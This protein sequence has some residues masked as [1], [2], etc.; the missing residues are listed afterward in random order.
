MND[1]TS[2]YVTD[3]GYPHGYYPELN[4]L[5][6]RLALARVALRSPPFVTACELGFGQGVSIN[7]HA[8]AAMTRW[9]GN[10]F[11]PAQVAFAEEAA[12]AAGSGIALS[13]EAFAEFCTRPDL[14]DC[15]FVG[16][17]GVWSW[18]SE[19]NRAVIVDFLRRK[20]K[21]G[22]VVYVGYNALP[23]WAPPAAL[24]HLLVTHTGRMTAPGPGLPA[25]IDAAFDFAA[26]LLETDP[27]YARLYPSVAS[28]LATAQKHHRHYLAHEYLNRDW[29]PMYFS[30]LAESLAAAKLT[31]A[32]SAHFLDHIDGLNLTPRQQAFL[33]DIPDLQLRE[34]ARDF[35]T[36]VQFRR[37]YWVKGARP[38][39][40]LEQLESLRGIRIVLAKPRS[41]V[42][43]T[44]IGSCG[45]ASLD[46]QIY[47]PILAALDDHKVRTIAEIEAG[48]AASGIVPAQLFQAVTVLVGTGDLAVAQDP[49]ATMQAKPRTDRLNAWLMRKARSDWDVE[50]LASPVTGGGVPLDRIEQLFLLARAEG[51][52]RTEWSTLVHTLLSSHGQS[53][54]RDGRTLAGEEM[55]MALDRE[56][57][58]F[59]ERRLPILAAL[60]VA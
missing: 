56:C 55:R 16:L 41:E 58:E 45:E 40:L 14:P 15:D 21:V 59:C 7:I 5:R 3:V 22:G 39:H 33:A 24:R 57:Q 27:A 9:Y 42:T 26:K 53:L 25:R 10:D 34:T 52:P 23:G 6:A 51:R 8:A 44:A 46:A 49:S 31:Y 43:L 17:Q 47:G 50:V 1:W 37:T 60:M 48:L 29:T 32:C 18:I 20:L 13:D 19:T 2:G 28:R 11:N 35:I 38:L 12:A 4:P 30:E 36:N 54:Q